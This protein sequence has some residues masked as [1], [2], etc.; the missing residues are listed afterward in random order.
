METHVVF[1]QEIYDAKAPLQVNKITIK[2]EYEESPDLSYL[3]KYQSNWVEGAIDRKKLGDTERN[4]YRYFVP[5]NSELEYAMNDYNRSE[6]AN[7]GNWCMM[8]CRAVAEIS[9]PT[10]NGRR[11]DRLRSGGLWGIES[12]SSKEYIEEIEKEEMADLKG[13]VEKFGIESWPFEGEE[14]WN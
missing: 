6:A 1:E 14:T 4:Q 7:R 9:Y 3:G 12:D 11:I 13:H 8:G 10:A 5:A 2:W